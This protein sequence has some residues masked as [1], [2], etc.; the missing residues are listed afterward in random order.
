[1]VLYSGILVITDTK[2]FVLVSGNFI[3]SRQCKAPPTIKI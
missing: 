2:L 1:M 3:N